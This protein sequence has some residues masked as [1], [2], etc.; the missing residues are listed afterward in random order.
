M[1]SI[2]MFNQGIWCAINHISVI[3]SALRLTHML[4]LS[5]HQHLGP[6]LSNYIFSQTWC[7]SS[8]WPQLHRQEVM[9]CASLGLWDPHNAE[10]RMHSVGTPSHKSTCFSFSLEGLEEE[11]I[12]GFIPPLLPLFWYLQ[13]KNDCIL[14]KILACRILRIPLNGAGTKLH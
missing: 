2:F 11:D 13:I 8:T 7:H 3:I 14:M 1:H 12:H 9:C 6:D 4:F 10:K 5:F